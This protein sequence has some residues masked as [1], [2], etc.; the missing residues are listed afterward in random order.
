MKMALYRHPSPTLQR[1]VEVRATQDGRIHCEHCGLWCKNRKE[2]EVDHVI[3]EKLRPL[4]DRQRPLRAVDLQLLCSRCH[5]SKTRDDVGSIAV[6][7]RREAR[8]RPPAAGP[9]RLQRQYE[10]K[11]TDE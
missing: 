9:T 2:Y 4:A 5:A 3:A 7:K 1:A 11:G 10:W 6:A 8:H